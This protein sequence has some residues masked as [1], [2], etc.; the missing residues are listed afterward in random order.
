MRGGKDTHKARESGRKLQMHFDF[1]SML[2]VKGA[3]K[4]RNRIMESAL[5]KLLVSTD[6]RPRVCR[7]TTP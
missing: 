4:G 2:V 6:N 5:K 7:G 3:G 1:L